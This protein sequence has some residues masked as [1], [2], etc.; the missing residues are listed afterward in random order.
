MTVI[1]VGPSPS[2]LTSI[3]ETPV[4]G[5]HESGLFQVNDTTVETATGSRTDQQAVISSGAKPT[6]LIVCVVIVAGLVGMQLLVTQPLGRQLHRVDQDLAR[7]ERDVSELVGA[8]DTAWESSDLLRGLQEQSRQLEGARNS[9]ATIREFR[10]QIANESAR[11]EAAQA[12]LTKLSGLQNQLIESDANAEQALSSLHRLVQ[13]R[14]LATSGADETNLAI[15]ELT[16]LQSLTTDLV[17]SHK[18][19]DQLV[20]LRDAILGGG[21][22]EIRTAARPIRERRDEQIRRGESEES[23]RTRDSQPGAVA[24]REISATKRTASEAPLFSGKYRLGL[25][26]IVPPPAESITP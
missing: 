7:V 2:G 1:G 23:R 22:E 12:S 13:L 26:R 3:G 4:Q 9:L 18:H 21:D 8:R 6:W 11:I 14:Q 19:L 5:Q 10:E 24:D 20:T 15:L 17:L 25:D 16:R